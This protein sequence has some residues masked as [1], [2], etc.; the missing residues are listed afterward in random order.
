[1]EVLTQGLEFH[2]ALAGSVAKRAH[3]PDGVEQDGQ[4]AA[5][6]CDRRDEGGS[7]LLLA[8]YLDYLG[9]VSLCVDFRKVSRTQV[10]VADLT[11]QYG[12]QAIVATL[13]WCVGT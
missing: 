4:F 8:H 1:M 3:E 11:M 2:E 10:A 9:V 6:L 12:H 7:E 5:H 13:F